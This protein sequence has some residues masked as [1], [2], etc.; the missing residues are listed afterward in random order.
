VKY[1]AVDDSGN[2]INH[3]LAEG[4]LHGG[5]MQGIGQAMGEVIVYDP[6]DGQPVHGSFM[7][8]FMPRADLLPP[9]QLIDRP[10]PSPTNPLGAKGVGEAGATGSVPTVAN[11]VIDALR[12]LGINHV[13]LPFSPH[14][15]WEAIHA[16]GK[17]Q[18][19]E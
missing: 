16:N 1:V 10:V 13:E 18:A 9:L 3:A 17:S 8:Y 5:L 19:A 12:S 15:I 11:A 6:I 4:Q 7:D 14:R 2:I